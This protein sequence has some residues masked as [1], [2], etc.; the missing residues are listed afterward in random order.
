VCNALV[1]VL[2]LF[3]AGGVLS[4]SEHRGYPASCVFK[5][6]RVSIPRSTD[7]APSSVCLGTYL[8]CPVICYHYMGVVRAGGLGGLFWRGWGSGRG[9]GRACA[10]VW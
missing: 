4:E 5:C 8:R 1:H 2:L 7:M 10:C 6:A 9:V 3:F